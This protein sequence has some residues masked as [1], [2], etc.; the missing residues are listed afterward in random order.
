M[1]ALLAR[2]GLL[3]TL[4]T[5]REQERVRI[6]SCS[7]PRLDAHEPVVKTLDL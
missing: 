4:I 5:S 7:W 6:Q 2:I 3:A 1:K